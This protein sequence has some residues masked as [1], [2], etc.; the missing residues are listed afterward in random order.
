MGTTGLDSYPEDLGLCLT[1]GIPSNPEDFKKWLEEERAKYERLEKE[2]ERNFLSVSLNNVLKKNVN[3]FN[4]DK[5]DVWISYTEPSCVTSHFR[6]TVLTNI[7]A[8]RFSCNCSYFHLSKLPKEWPELI[9][10][11]EAVFFGDYID[12]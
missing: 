9:P 6:E 7:D 4:G 2:L 10:S 12:N 11:A 3:T 5:L 1:S 8:E